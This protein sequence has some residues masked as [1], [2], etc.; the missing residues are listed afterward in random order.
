MEDFSKLL[1][2]KRKQAGLSIDDVC[3]KTRLTQKHIKALEDGNMEFFRDDLSYMRFFVKSYCE[4]VGMNYEDIKDLLR[5]SIDDYTQTISISALKDHEEMEKNIAHSEKLTKVRNTQEHAHV[6]TSFKQNKDK[7]IHKRIDFSLLSFVGAAAVVVLVVGIS[8]W[9]LGQSDDKDSEVKKEQPIADKQETNEKKDSPTEEKED[10]KTQD[11]EITK[12][13]LSQYTVE[14]VKAGDE[15][16]I[17]IYFGNASSAFSM[18][19]NGEVLSDPAAKVY[20]WKETIKTKIT[21][22]ENMKMTL[23]FGW[24][25]QIQVKING[26]IVNIDESIMNS[27]SACNLEFTMVEDKS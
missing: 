4:A 19:V 27:D 3:E 15:L 5:D 8:L 21:A 24:F 11:I 12:V 17:E 9:T 18:S 23:Y 22:K 25:N 13:G 10:K 7:K 26:K 6:R 14:N 1:K 20:Q 2:E 16:D